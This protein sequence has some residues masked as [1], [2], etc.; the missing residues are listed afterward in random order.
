MKKSK[1]PQVL[2]HHDKMSHKKTLL[3][4]KH[5]KHE[6]TNIEHEPILERLMFC[7]YKEFI[8]QM[9]SCQLYLYNIKKIKINLGFL[10]DFI[11]WQSTIILNRKSCIPCIKDYVI[12]YVK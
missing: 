5:A 2:G 12:S 10:L 8:Q 9:Q 7:L 3:N 4:K 11:F 6:T 1:Q